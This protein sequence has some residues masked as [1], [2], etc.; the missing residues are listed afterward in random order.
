MLRKLLIF[1]VLATVV[2]TAGTI[3]LNNLDNYANQ[4]VPAYILRDN[5]PVANPITDAGA[6]LGRVLFYDKKLSI[7][8]SISCASCHKQEFAFGDTAVQ[9]LGVAG[10]TGR[11]SMRL[12][13]AR[14][15]EE[16]KFFWD[17]RASS[18]EDQS[19][20]PIQDHIEMGFSGTSGDP[21]LDSLVRKLNQIEYYN[22]LF[23]FVYGDTVITE[24][25]MQNALAQ[26][27]RS[28]QSFDS[29]YDVGRAQVANDG[30]NFPNFSAMENMGKNI[31]LAPP[32]LG[33]GCQGCH[34]APE[35]DIDPNT[36]NNGEIN[37]AGGGG[38]DLT[39]TRAPSLRDLFNPNGTLNG[40][41]FHSAVFN[42]I[43]QVI[44][45]YNAVPQIP[46]NTNLDPRLQ[47]PGG[48]LNLTQ[49]EKD[50][51]EAFLRTLSGNNIYTDPKWSDPFD[52]NGNIDLILVTTAI[53][54]TASLEVNI[55]PNPAGN[56]INIDLPDNYYNVNIMNING[57]VLRTVS[58]YGKENLDISE[59]PSGALLVEITENSS[60]KRIVK[61]LIKK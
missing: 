30:V 52:N 22:R 2:I 51:L 10:V 40:P 4:P 35:F 5:M 19:T 8:N 27:V 20:R 54:N 39:N 13:N 29:R 37:V 12:V 42:N 58:L 56:Y 38:T 36:L 23:E 44:N 59:L 53:N 45:H 43:Q 41:L 9:S 60:G 47:G 7:D 61:K 55:Y 32:P 17:E 11:H 15:S 34:R 31:F 6:T 25:R 26:F 48:Q 24:A 3:D 49:Q 1:S 14:F 16:T 28:I 33:A 46:A 50:A 18:L 57:Q 21:D